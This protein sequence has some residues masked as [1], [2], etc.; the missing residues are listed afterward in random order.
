[1]KGGNR[2]MAGTSAYRLLIESRINR[3]ASEAGITADLAAIAKNKQLLIGMKIDVSSSQKIQEELNR[4]GTSATKLGQIKIFSNAEGEIKKFT[5]SYTDGVGKAASSTVVLN[6]KVKATQVYTQNLSKEQANYNKLLEQSQNLA[7]RQA[8]ELHQAQINALAFLESSKNKAG[9]QQLTAART[10][11]EQIRVAVSEGDLNKVRE[12]NDQLKIQKSALSGARTGMDSWTEG[13]KRAMR[14]TIEY[15]ASVGLV[16]GALRQLKEGIQYVSDLNKE[17]VNIQQ[18]Q[19]TGAQTNDEIAQLAVGFNDLAK[20]M[21]ATTIEVAKGSTE[22]LR[23]GK[24][25]AETQE[26]LKSTLML[27]KLGNLDTAQATEYLTAIVNGFKL[28]AS[29]AETVVSKLVAI[30]NIAATSA[31]ELAAAMQRSSAVAQETGVSFDKLA[32][33]IGAVSNSTRLSAEMIGTAFRSM[34]VRMTE[35]K[36]G[37]IDETGKVMPEQAV[38]LGII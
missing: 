26:L 12:L 36:A 7:A 9:S 21:G 10:T 35:V 27:S 6:E 15:A 14:Q 30:D 37:A 17:L 24:S 22:W 4:I 38:M 25:I 13:M 1:M 18:L 20:G 5:V 23:Q 19:Q 2:N 28:S 31:G 11:A 33:Y 16:F 3:A 29:D 8:D 32:A 34:M